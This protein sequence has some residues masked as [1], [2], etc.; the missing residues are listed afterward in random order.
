MQL[1][2]SNVFL[3]FSASVVTGSLFRMKMGLRGMFAAGVL[4]GSFG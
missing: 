2:N 4:G 3:M 1:K